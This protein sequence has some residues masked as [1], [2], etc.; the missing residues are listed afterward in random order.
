MK[1]KIFVSGFEPFTTID[2]PEKI[3]SVVFLQ[4]CN[5]DCEYCSNPE[6]KKIKNP[7]DFG[8]NQE[9]NWEYILDGLSQRKDFIEAV[10]FS[11]GEALVQADELSVAIDNVKAIN[12]NFKIGLH[13][14]GVLPN[15]L[16]KVI[17]KIDW[18][19]FD[20]KAPKS[21]YCLLSA[22]GVNHFS[23]IE[24]SLDLIIKNGVDFEVRTTCYP[25]ILTKDDV[26]EIADF[27]QA[28]GVKTFALQKFI[29]FTGSA[30]SQGIN[31]CDINQFFTDEELIK[32][33][34]SYSFKLI[35]RE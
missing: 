27:C 30:K 16:E 20:I 25:K 26:I 4:G 21:K 23:N 32:R 8:E 5:L 35:L 22:N 3:S 2:Y 12:P 34:K 14:N 17:G 18:I 28:K 19:G 7:S 33:L 11:G 31:F 6:T 24:K 13:T 9:N 1:A 10:V 29:D 15:G